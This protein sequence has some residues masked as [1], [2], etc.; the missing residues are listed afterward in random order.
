MQIIRMIF[1]SA[2]MLAVFGGAN[3]YVARRLLG[4]LSIIFP[5]INTKIYTG[6]YVFLAL[7]MFFGFF[8]FPAGI[9]I[10][11]NRLGV[12]F[13]SFFIYLLVFI[14]LA[15]FIILVGSLIKLVPSP[16]PQSVHFY[17][18][19]T[20]IILTIG[21]VGYGLY[22]ATGFKLVTYELEVKDSSLS[23]MTIVLISDSHLG[24]VNS[25]ENNLER[26]VEEINALNPDIVCLAGDIFNDDFNL[27]RDPERASA[28]LR[29]IDS[30]YGVF[31]CLGNHDGGSTLPEMIS[32]LEKSSITLLNDEYVILDN[33]VAL[34]GRLDAYPIG[35][36]GELERRDISDVIARVSQDY[37]VIVIDHNPAHI[38]EYGSEA[39]LLLFG[40]AHNGQMFP[41][42][43]ITDA[44]NVIGY[45]H[46]QEGENSPHIIVTSGISTWGPPIRIGTSNEIVCIYLK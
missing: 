23:G 44:I 36:F 7:S 43:F 24:A 4:W 32:F 6:V 37:P 34:F 9:K 46:Y 29:G 45:G 19:L 21:V 18:G 20:A 13:Y 15:D 14:L 39:A 30:T 12:Y 2:A 35:G 28:L 42:M 31:A 26:I 11:F 27:I 17:K 3:F 5:G 25:F 1:I 10:I 33:G 40:H 41:G 16:L 8:P 22:N 38:K